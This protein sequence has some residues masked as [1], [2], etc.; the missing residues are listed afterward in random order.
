MPINTVAVYCGS[1]LGNQPD[2]GQ[3]ARDLARALAAHRMGLVYGG[4]NV[5]I[6]GELADACLRERVCV[7]G[8]IPG[9]LVDREIAHRGIDRLEVVGTMAERKTRMEELADAFVILP[10]GMGTMEELFQVMTGQQIGTIN[11]PIALCNT[12]GYYDGLVETLESMA[13]CGFVQ[14]KF[15]TSLIVAPTPGDVLNRMR[16]WKSPGTKWE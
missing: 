4:G 14:Q 7:T 12:N 5:G 8:V 9:G 11:G 6:M 2:F 15:V 13:R 1:A 10:G 16:C 3:A